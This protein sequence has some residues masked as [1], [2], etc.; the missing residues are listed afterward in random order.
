MTV[1]SYRT[2]AAHGRLYWGPG[3]PEEEEGRPGALSV[4]PGRRRGQTRN[5]LVKVAASGRR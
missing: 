2:A 5:W 1:L 3:L 4:L